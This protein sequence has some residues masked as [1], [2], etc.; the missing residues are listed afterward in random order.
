[1]ASRNAHLRTS[2]A[3]KSIRFGDSISRTRSGPQDIPANLSDVKRGNLAG[4]R[5][6]KAVWGIWG[7]MDWWKCSKC[8]AKEEE[9][10]RLRGSIE[11]KNETLDRMLG[12]VIAH[13]SAA[14]NAAD[15]LHNLRHLVAAKEDELQQLREDAEHM[16]ASLAA[17]EEELHKLQGAVKVK[18]DA[19]IAMR[20]AMCGMRNAMRDKDDLIARP[21]APQNS[22]SSPA[23]IRPLTPS[24]EASG[25]AAAAV[26][27]QASVSTAVVS[28]GVSGT[29]GFRWA[30]SHSSRSLSSGSGCGI[31]MEVAD[32]R[33]YGVDDLV[34]EEMRV[35]ESMLHHHYTSFP[36]LPRSANRASEGMKLLERA[37]GKAASFLGLDPHQHRH[38]SLVP[39]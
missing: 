30:R 9:L 27:G 18:D 17:V 13:Q 21:A 28:T 25:L 8:Q 23:R 1:M 35:A 14:A 2:L 15:E 34:L 37:V 5:P 12:A 32:T 24:D 6:R 38:A 31:E 4:S 10:H 7:S 39:S 19:L 16:R 22:P 20:V 3:K 11:A 29:G 36:P 26:G 33:A